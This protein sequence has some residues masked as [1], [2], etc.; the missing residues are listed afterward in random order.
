MGKLG[1]L[2]EKEISEKLRA[3]SEDRMRKE[4]RWSE[5]NFTHIKMPKSINN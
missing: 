2:S 5:K 3:L 1:K 4:W